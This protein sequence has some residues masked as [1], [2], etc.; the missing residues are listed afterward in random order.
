MKLLLAITFTYLSILSLASA[1]TLGIGFKIQQN[2]QKVSVSIY[3]TDRRQNKSGMSLEEAII[4]V[5]AQYGSADSI[6]VG[7]VADIPLV[8]YISLLKA[9]SENK[10]M[11]LS[12]VDGCGPEIAH[13]N[14]RKKIEQG[15]AANP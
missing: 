13:Q 1:G 5:R 10:F 7:I 8:N 11:C 2:N 12:F 3:S 4:F 15:A 14:L 9:I 6:I